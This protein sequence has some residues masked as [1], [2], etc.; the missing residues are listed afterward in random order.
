MSR[1][2]NQSNAL[3]IAPIDSIIFPKY[4]LSCQDGDTKE[5]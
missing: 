4:A 5:Q 3:W 2:K 1:V